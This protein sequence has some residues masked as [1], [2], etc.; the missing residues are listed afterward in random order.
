MAP[1]CCRLGLFDFFHASLT[2]P[3]TTSMGPPCRT[4][5]R[6]REDS[7]PP[8][9]RGR[10]SSRRLL[11]IGPT[12]TLLLRLNWALP[13]MFHSARC[14]SSTPTRVRLVTQRTGP[15]IGAEGRPF[16]NRRSH[17]GRRDPRML[18]K[19]AHFRDAW[20]RNDKVGL[21]LCPLTD[22]TSAMILR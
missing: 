12:Q 14:R 18:S 10:G 20:E 7:V 15:Q 6:S 4:K 21:Q 11:L 22:P 16:V 13:S 5:K 19:I 1:H 3:L 8:T 2:I 9:M 17:Y